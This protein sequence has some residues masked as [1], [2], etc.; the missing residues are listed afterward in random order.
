M[1]D[2]AKQAAHPVHRQES[3][4]SASLLM[5]FHFD[6]TDDHEFRSIFA[7]RS[8]RGPEHGLVMAVLQEAIENAMPVKARLDGHKLRQRLELQ[9]EARNW[10]N[11]KPKRE[12]DWPYTFERICEWMRYD[13]EWL[14]DRI[15]DRIRGERRPWP[16]KLRKVKG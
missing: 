8:P 4:P 15:W 2:H 10:I 9:A 16:V 13:V 5:P 3:K 1:T 6:P 12:A 14:R 11:G 7:Q